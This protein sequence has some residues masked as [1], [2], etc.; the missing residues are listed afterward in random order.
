MQQ[1]TGIGPDTVR[2]LGDTIDIG[3]L[4]NR[5][6]HLDLDPETVERD[7]ARLVLALVEFLRRLMEYQAI[8]RMERGTLTEEEVERVGTALMKARDTI[9]GLAGQFGLTEEDL[10]LD[11]G[12][13]GK[14]F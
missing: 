9:S 11:L 6:D 2:D 10:R 1:E 13:L 5:I 12:P 4:K 14:L 7:L 8:G 3:A